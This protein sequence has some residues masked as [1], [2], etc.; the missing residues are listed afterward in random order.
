MGI[1]KAI[2]QHHQS[3]LGL[4]PTH[5]NGSIPIDGIFISYSIQVEA[6]GYFPFGMIQSDHRALWIKIQF[7]QLFGHEIQ[8]FVLLIY[9]RVQC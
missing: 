1:H 5:Q 4:Q 3:S 2:T 8:N 9:R 6:E 7:N